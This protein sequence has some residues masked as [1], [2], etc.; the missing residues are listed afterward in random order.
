[1]NIIRV[2][3]REMIEAVAALALDI[4]PAHYTPIIGRPQVDYM[5]E[6]FQSPAAIRAQIADGLEYYLFVEDGCMAGYMAILP[7]PA[8]GRMLLSKFY[9]GS[10]FRGR[11]FGRAALMFVEELCRKLALKVLWLTV[12]R[13]NPTVAVYE[14]LG[15]LKAGELQ[16]DIGNGFIL[17]DY[18]MEKTIG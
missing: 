17:D 2:T 10:R 11:G 4:W 1:M 13:F 14:A 16:T 3:D 9:V 8:E 15:F 18:I 7:E 12:N 6:K 5:L